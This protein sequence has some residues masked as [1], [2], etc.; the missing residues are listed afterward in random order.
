MRAELKEKQ[1]LICEAATA[2]NLIEQTQK[3][4]AAEHA[5][6]CK[7]LHEQKS[8][9]EQKNHELELE[10][11]AFRVVSNSSETLA[12]STGN[13]ESQIDA[14]EA[15][16]RQME[17]A[18]ARHAEQMA[19]A[20]NRIAAQEEQVRLAEQQ[21]T[22]LCVEMEQLKKNASAPVVVVRSPGRHGLARL[23]GGDAKLQQSIIDEATLQLRQQLADRD[24]EII[25]LQESLA[26][27][28]AAH[29]T[30]CNALMK[31]TIRAKTLEKELKKH[32]SVSCEQW[33]RKTGIN[34][35]NVDNVSSTY[36]LWDNV[37]MCNKYCVCV[38]IQLI[39]N[40]NRLAD[41]AARQKPACAFWSNSIDEFE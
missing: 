27:K 38:L 13:N 12:R 4:N 33:N 6:R 16:V 17:I 36:S 25:S 19:D 29:D 5:A 7:E 9:T 8:R 15:N 22:E 34:S 21:Y 30:G 2:L 24:C 1:S 26:A 31:M 39:R 20:E 10:L 37:Q 11:Q 41:E 3:S 23:E 40:V 35:G 18:A 28:Q 14:L 32:Q